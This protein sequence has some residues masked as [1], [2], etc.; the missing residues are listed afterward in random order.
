MTWG[1]GIREKKTPESVCWDA[2]ADEKGHFFVVGPFP[3]GRPSRFQPNPHSWL[4]AR[5]SPLPP[6]VFSPSGAKGRSLGCQCTPSRARLQFSTSFE[7]A[8]GL[9]CLLWQS[10]RHAMRIF[11]L[12]AG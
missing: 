9:A 4:M 12:G 1:R 5:T 8:P 3:S 2:G 6:S 11:V 7:D 10:F